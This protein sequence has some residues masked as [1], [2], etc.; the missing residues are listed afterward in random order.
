MHFAHLKNPYR[1]DIQSI[2]LSFV[3]VS[4]SLGSICKCRF[5]LMKTHRVLTNQA[6]VRFF[7]VMPL[8]YNQN[9]TKNIMHTIFEAL[10]NKISIRNSGFIE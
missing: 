5:L 2:V 9:K 3:Y 10:I 8:I 7:I 1:Q 4:F 6:N